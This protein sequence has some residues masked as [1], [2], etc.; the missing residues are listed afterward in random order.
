MYILSIY[1]IYS[2]IIITIYGVELSS[3]IIHF[4]ESNSITYYANII[5]IFIIIIINSIVLFNV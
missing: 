3:S 5:L 1:M 4:N 2:S